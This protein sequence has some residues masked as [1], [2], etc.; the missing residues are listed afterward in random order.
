[1]KSKNKKIGRFDIKIIKNNDIIYNAFDIVINMLYKIINEVNDNISQPFSIEYNGNNSI[2]KVN[3]V[4]N[5]LF[6]SMF[7][8]Y[9]E[10]IKKCNEYVYILYTKKITKHIIN[11]LVDDVND[12]IKDIMYKNVGNIFPMFPECIGYVY[13]EYSS[14]P[15]LCKPREYL[16]INENILINYLKNKI[17]T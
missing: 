7:G 2:R 8:Q 11:T 3:V 15:L 5:D 17:N 12:L 9:I 14:L 4:N 16:V 6:M 1:M 13:K 10:Y